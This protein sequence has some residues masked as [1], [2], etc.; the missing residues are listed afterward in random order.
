MKLLI[1][2]ILRNDEGNKIVVVPHKLLNTV[3]KISLDNNPLRTKSN[4]N[5]TE[6]F[7]SYHTADS[8]SIKNRDGK[9]CIRKYSLLH[10]KYI[11][12]KSY[13]LWG[14]CISF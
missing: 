8:V 14:E 9:C 7:Y 11:N 4:M 1:I 12:I 13:S 6:R 3:R 5:Y 10:L 2:L